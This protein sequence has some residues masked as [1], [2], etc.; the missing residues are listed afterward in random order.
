MGD[1]NISQISEAPVGAAL[2]ATVNQ[3]VFPPGWVYDGA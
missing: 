3:D 1:R 2:V